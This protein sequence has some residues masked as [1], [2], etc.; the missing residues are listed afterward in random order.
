MESVPAPA[1]KKHNP[2]YSEYMKIYYEKNRDVINARRRTG[3]P[4]GRPRRPP[5][6]PQGEG[7]YSSSS[8]SESVGKSV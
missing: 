6:E 4:R 2:P 5:V 3:N 7:G 1:P 8:S